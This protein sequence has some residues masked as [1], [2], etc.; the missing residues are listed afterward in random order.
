MSNHT[1]SEEQLR[2]MLLESIELMER[3][4]AGEKH[5]I[6]QARRAAALA[7]AQCELRAVK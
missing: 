7:N 3:V 6:P 5:L 2:K 1:V 4:A